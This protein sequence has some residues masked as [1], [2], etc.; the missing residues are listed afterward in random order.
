[1]NPPVMIPQEHD[2]KVDN[3]SKYGVEFQTKVLSAL[4]T[5]IPFLEQ[6]FDIIN[7]HFFDTDEGKWV[8]EKILSYYS[9]YRSSPT[10]DYFKIELS[11][12]TDETLKLSCKDILVKILRA[13]KDT[14]LKYVQDTFLDFAK[15]QSL[16]SAIIRS[17]DL[18]QS[19]QYDSIKS[20]VDN[21]L[22]SGQP[23]NIGHMWLD[24]I[25]ERLISSPRNTISTGWP[26]IDSISGGG[27]AGGELG[28]IVAPS[29]AG[30][31]WVLSHLGAVALKQNKTVVHYT[32]ELNDKYLGIRY[33]T[34][35]TGIEP[36]K[37]PNNY[38]LVKN[39]IQKIPGKLIIK[40]YPTKGASANTL[41]TH[42]QQLKSLGHPPDIMLVDYAD[43]LRSTE[44]SDGKYEEMGA[45]YDQLR[46]LAGE[47]NIPCWTASQSQ[48][49]SIQDDIIQADKIADSYQKIMKGDLVISVSRK[50]EDKVSGTGRLH[51]IKN[52]FGPDGLTYPATINTTIGKIEAYEENSH[53][54]VMVRE[55]AKVA[56]VDSKK[57]LLK[58]LSQTTNTTNN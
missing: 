40:Y 11:S 13:S 56:E 42:I 53:D 37:I 25:D 32:L 16:K 5:D 39:T 35:F 29:G 12:E 52:R 30:K 2:P 20:L 46:G 1:M 49:S 6:S 54:G 44:R 36:G 21:A 22:R 51:I 50:L 4:I 18:L 14:D 58:L 19:G 24:D 23:K 33:D 7:P 28:V 26:V 57:K 41:L 45:I 55:A 10:I 38:D 47:L 43:L 48:R 27:L 9:Q 8:S 31:S 3:L 17:V 15:N 34:I